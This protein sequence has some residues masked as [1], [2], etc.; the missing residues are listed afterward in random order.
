LLCQEVIETTLNCLFKVEIGVVVKGAA[1]TNHKHKHK[2]NPADVMPLVGVVEVGQDV[3]DKFGSEVTR[4]L[5]VKTY[6]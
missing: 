5:L 4:D 6:P 1:V 3:L 2:L